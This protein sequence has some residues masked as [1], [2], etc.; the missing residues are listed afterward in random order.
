MNVFV[1]LYFYKHADD[2]ED[3]ILR[4]ITMVETAN[5]IY[6][7][8]WYCHLGSKGRAKDLSSDILKEDLTL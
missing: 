4:M 6:D 2:D 1:Y 7:H 8:E 3:R 5:S